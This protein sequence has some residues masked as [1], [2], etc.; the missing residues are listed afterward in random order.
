MNQKSYLLKRE[1]IKILKLKEK[2]QNKKFD[3]MVEESL[4]ALKEGRVYEF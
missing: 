1:K 3:N 4:Q 2:E